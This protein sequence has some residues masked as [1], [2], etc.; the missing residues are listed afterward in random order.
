MIKIG[1][2]GSRG[3]PDIMGGVE[4]HC[5]EL[6]PR[7][8]D[9]GIEIIVCRRKPYVTSGTKNKTFNNIRFIDVWCLKNKYFEAFFHTMVSVLIL[10]F[11]R[12][13]ILHVH[14]IGPGFWIFFANLLGFKTVL[15][16]HT[17]DYIRKKWG[18]FAKKF[19]RFSEFIA[20]TFATEII[21]TSKITSGAISRQY[22]RKSHYLP[23]GISFR[24]SLSADKFCIERNLEK[25]KYVLFVGRLVPEKEIQDLILAFAKIRTD[26]KLV[27]AG[28]ADHEDPY[29]R[30]I[31]KIGN[32]TRNV[33]FTGVIKGDKLGEAYSNAG[34]FV[35][36]SSLEG[37][38]SALL[39]AIGYGLPSIVSD[40]PA[41]R[42]IGY[43]AIKYFRLH[44]IDQLA[45]LLEE[46]IKTPGNMDRTAGKQ[47]L[48]EN[49]NQDIVALKI[50]NIYKKL[51]RKLEVQNEC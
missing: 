10:R 5:E 51:V 26:W 32:E 42:D 12:V 48:E 17:P 11:H 16:F 19:L 50:L 4:K 14:S 29:S 30:W 35:L 45:S 22:K 28:D 47:F 44:D 25:G 13:S 46:E 24:H 3:F 9:L 38:S 7:L 23:S 49:F 41:N 8:A 2:I 18:Y 33:V 43:E 21:A 27:I 1:V 34:C 15:T 40:I 31:K 39:E 37:M 6:Y 20:C 36:P